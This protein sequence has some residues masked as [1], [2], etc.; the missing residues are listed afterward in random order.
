MGLGQ[1][2]GQGAGGGG[3]GGRQGL[4]LFFPDRVGPVL[5]LHPGLQG[6]HRRLHDYAGRAGV[7]LKTHV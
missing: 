1:G 5:G 4:N 2:R 6:G 3:G 7:P